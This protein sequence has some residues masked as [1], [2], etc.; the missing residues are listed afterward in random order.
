MLF[1]QPNLFPE[2]QTHTSY[3]LLNISTGYQP[4]FSNV[5]CSEQNSRSSLS[6]SAF[7]LYSPC[8][9]M[10]TIFLVVK[11]PNFGVILANQVTIIFCLD[12]CNNPLIF[13]LSSAFV[14]S[15]S[16]LNTAAEVIILKM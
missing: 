10:M 6:N 5:T 8:Q 4:G 12:Y 15:Q 2:L 11:V 7:P 3:C 9:L 1:I 16:V 14:A 13:P